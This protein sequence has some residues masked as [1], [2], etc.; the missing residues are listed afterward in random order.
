MSAKLL[1]MVGIIT[2][3]VIVVSLSLRAET[4]PFVGTWGEEFTNAPEGCSDPQKLFK[5]TA[6]LHNGCKI[7]SVK[8]DKYW[9]YLTAKCK[10][11][12]E[13]KY[14]LHVENNILTE[15]QLA[16]NDSYKTTA[17]DYPRCN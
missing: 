4:Y 8:R 5:I 12:K 14:S 2:C 9:Y 11:S 7:T 13:E 3:L 6:T 17:F 10:G 1:K 15:Q 16:E